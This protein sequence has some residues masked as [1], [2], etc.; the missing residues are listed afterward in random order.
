MISVL[1]LTMTLN[2][3]KAAF[4][5]FRDPTLFHLRNKIMLAMAWIKTQ[6]ENSLNYSVNTTT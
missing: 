4:E 1:T 3:Q 6:N 5:I 2:T